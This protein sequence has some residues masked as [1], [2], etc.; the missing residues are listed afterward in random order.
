MTARFETRST[1]DVPAAELF[2]LITD[3]GYQERR[4]RFGGKQGVTATRE[5]EADDTT[6]VTIEIR[7]PAVFGGGESRRTMTLRFP[8]GSMRGTWKQR[9]H[10]QEERVHADGHTEVRALG[11]RRCE[12]V[13]SAR[14]ELD[15][16]M[17]GRAIERQVKA[18]FVRQAE[19][20]EAFTRRELRQR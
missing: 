15:I 5:T 19:R 8:E 20:E 18:A 10:G 14:I 11:E 6:V 1:Y 16:P 12:L 9:I 2:A 4:V 3:P 7:E 17:V 13:T